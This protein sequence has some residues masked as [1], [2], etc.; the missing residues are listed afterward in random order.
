MSHIKLS[1]L[2]KAHSSQPTDP[3]ILISTP[4]G[5]VVHFKKVNT[6]VSFSKDE[7]D[8]LTPGTSLLASD[9]DIHPLLASEVLEH[10]HVDL[11]ELSRLIY[12]KGVDT[13]LTNYSFGTSGYMIREYVYDNKAFDYELHQFVYPGKTF[14]KTK[15][16]NGVVRIDSDAFEKY[17]NA[18]IQFIT[19]LAMFESKYER[20]TLRVYDLRHYG[21]HYEPGL[22]KSMAKVIDDQFEGVEYTYFVDKSTGVDSLVLGSLELSNTDGENSN[23]ITAHSK[24]KLTDLP[25]LHRVHQRIKPMIILASLLNKIVT[26]K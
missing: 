26:F 14:L 1:M 3:F 25:H 12:S 11:E 17:T 15:L 23:T 16:S 8:T 9:Y 4:E 6:S 13:L 22:L 10:L 24:I 18:V 7:L 20:D 2:F 21:I 19:S 5:W